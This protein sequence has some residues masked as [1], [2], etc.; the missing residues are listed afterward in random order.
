[1]AD[2]NIVVK[3]GADITSFSRNMQQATQKLTDFT[4]KTK[5][6]FDAFK[7]VGTIFTGFGLAAGAGFGAAIKT[8]ADFESS[9]SR[10]GAISGASADDMK[11]LTDAAKLAGE[12]TAWSASESAEA[13]QYLALAGWKTNDMIAGLPGM[14]NLAS[15]GALD[16]A[17]AADITSDMMSMFGIE[18]DKAGYVADVFAKAST[19]ANTDVQQLGEALKYLGAN[20]NALGW[21][22]E[23][24]SAAIMALADSGVKGSMAGQAFATSLGRLA[25]PT[26]KMEGLMKDLGIS[27]FDSEGNMKSM[28][29]VIKELETGMKGMN[30]Q[31]KSA[32]LTTLFGAE[33]FKHW[34]ILMNRGSDDLAN[35]TQALRDSGGTAEEVANKQLDNLNGQIIM[36]KSALEGAAITVGNALLPALKATTSVV[37]GVVDWFN[38][39]SES[40]KSVVA[41]VGALAAGLLLIG[42]PLLLLIGFIPQILIGLTNLGI[43]AKGLGAA[44]SFVTGPIG[45]VILAIAGLVT[46][47]VIAYQKVEWFRDMV[48]AAFGFIRD[49]VSA[50]LSAVVSFVTDKLGYITQFW[51]ENSALIKEATRV[52][53]NF[54]KNDIQSGLK[55]IQG[56]FQAVFPVIQGIVKIAW[57]V[58]KLAFSNGI[59]LVLGIIKVF[60][61]IFTGDWKGAFE[62]AKETASKILKN[63]V[64]TFKSIDLLTIGKNIVQGLI[65]GLG[66]MF[67]AVKEKVASLADLVPS[68]VKKLLGIH[69]PSRVLM[70]LGEFTGEGFEDGLSGSLNGIMKSVKAITQSVVGSFKVIEP[71]VAMPNV[72]MS[73]DTPDAKLI[74]SDVKATVVE[75]AS[76]NLDTSRVEQLLEKLLYKDT[77]IKID[78]REVAVATYKARSTYDYGADK[79]SM[80]WEGY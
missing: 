29:N 69:S 31:Q 35:M 3:L 17:T 58:I 20:A 38:G 13:L 56:I 37:Q 36:L 51:K 2:Q 57:S 52:V 4:N 50:A 11:R 27:F 59:D 64:S 43:V 78:A 19:S 60:A 44:M 40:T 5:K 32:A 80:R 12:T 26:S 10:V 75:P 8:A 46:A 55:F 24:S 22:I 61:K 79:L 63:I 30:A 54:I 71:Q 9:M 7:K 28:P 23:Q 74:T 73:Y 33:A 15:A 53:M 47:A 62:T 42:G 70:T 65:N 14:L 41:T 21:D 25:K 16:L 76:Q 49:Q 6:T 48:N 67:D 77:S 1:M 72:S 66:S 39:L 45:L 68:G 18:A 34:Q